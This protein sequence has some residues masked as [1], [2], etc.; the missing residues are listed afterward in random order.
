MEALGAH[1]LEQAVERQGLGHEGDLARHLLEDAQ[2]AVAVEEVLD[3]DE[4]DDVVEVPFA[5]R[6]AGVAAAPRDPQVLGQRPGG[7]EVDHVL[8]REHDL[9]R[10]PVGQLEDVVEQLALLAAAGRLAWRRGQEAGAAPPRRGRAPPRRPAAMP[11]SFS[12]ALAV[13]LSSQMAG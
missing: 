1:A 4:A 11:T 8:A 9:P 3:V 13:W 5:E 10:H 6:E 2:V 7:G 12:S